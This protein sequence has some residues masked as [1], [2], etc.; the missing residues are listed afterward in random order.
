MSNT[1]NGRLMRIQA[2]LEAR[3]C[4]LASEVNPKTP[5]YRDMVYTPESRVCFSRNPCFTGRETELEA[6]REALL[7]CTQVLVTGPG[8]S[9]K[10]Q[11]AL[12]YAHRYGDAYRCVR[13]IPARTE[14]ALLRA[15]A[16]LAVDARLASR[17]SASAPRDVTNWMTKQRDCLFIYD[18][19]E[20]VDALI[21]WMQHDYRY[22]RQNPQKCHIIL[23]TRLDQVHYNQ[24]YYWKKIEA[25]P[26]T[27]EEAA[28]F[29][30]KRTG[31]PDCGEA[32]EL[33]SRLGYFPLS[34]SL[35]AA[36]VRDILGG[37]AAAMTILPAAL[38]GDHQKG[39]EAATRLA[40]RR[41]GG[42]ADRNT[43][44]LLYLCAH[45]APENLLPEMMSAFFSD[46]VPRERFQA[47]AELGL[48][49]PQAMGGYTMPRPVQAFIL[50]LLEEKEVWANHVLRVLRGCY[51]YAPRANDAFLMLS[52]HVEAFVAAATGI[53]KTPESRMGLSALCVTRGV[54]FERLSYW[55]LAVEG[56]K[57]AL[58]LRKKTPAME[59]EET[60]LIYYHIALAYERMSKRSLAASW[61]KKATELREKL[62]G[63]EPPNK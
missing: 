12:E 46:T 53:L 24:V 63:P 27:Q 49:R 22:M 36:A 33:A 52:P 57:Q 1:E 5:V 62:L 58:A 13:W 39:L 59:S 3:G 48:M 7:G 29:L 40:L 43:A 15:Y 8:G 60:S 25:V 11:L 34:L 54:G 6:M 19:V 4:S 45:L 56:Y 51:T 30:Q 35:M 17:Y 37:F 44:T 14:T 26:F 20:D 28:E 50:E 41:L 31:L 42:K 32:R 18:D 2:A 9:G 16:D 38:E 21:K 10:T 23:T 47:L 61:H 55:A